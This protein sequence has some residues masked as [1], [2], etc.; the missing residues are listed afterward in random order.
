MSTRD[1]PSLPVLIAAIGAG[2]IRELTNVELLAVIL[3]VEPEEAAALCEDA[4]G[5][6]DIELKQLMMLVPAYSDTDRPESHQLSEVAELVR[7]LQSLR[8][9]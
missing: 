4:F 8:G 3:A 6:S 7:W 9:R 5:T 2:R 1:L